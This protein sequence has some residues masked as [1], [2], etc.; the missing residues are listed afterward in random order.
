[1]DSQKS[2]KKFIHPKKNSW[3][4]VLSP[5]TGT[6]C[7]F[8]KPECSSVS[9]ISQHT[10]LSRDGASFQPRD[11][12]LHRADKVKLCAATWLRLS[13]ETYYSQDGADLYLST[14]HRILRCKEMTQREWLWNAAIAFRNLWM[15]L[16]KARQPSLKATCCGFATIPNDLSALCPCD[17][18]H[19]HAGGEVA[20]NFEFATNGGITAC[21]CSY[22][23]ISWES[24]SSPCVCRGVT[25][26]GPCCDAW[27]SA[28]PGLRRGPSACVSWIA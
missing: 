21:Q 8:L 7:I 24:R 17:S 10:M 28:G 18:T 1:M 13:P 20:D 19:K 12:S 15:R 27:A 16:K 26:Q 9:S 11:I 22:L 2:T 23:P 3:K 25:W 14:L 5:W 6:H 4:C